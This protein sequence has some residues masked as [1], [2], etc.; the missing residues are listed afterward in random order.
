MN[1]SLSPR[2]YKRVQRWIRQNDF[3]V[4]ENEE[5]FERGTLS[6]WDLTSDITSVSRVQARTK[7]VCECD[8]IKVEERADVVKFESPF[9]PPQD[10]EIS[11]KPIS[12][13]NL[14]SISALPP[15]LPISSNQ[16]TK[17]IIAG[18]ESE[19]RKSDKSSEFSFK[20]I[21]TSAYQP[22]TT[23][24]YNLPS[25]TLNDNQPSRL[26]SSGGSNYMVPKMQSRIPDDPNPPS[27]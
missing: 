22:S 24:K 2:T 15:K 25:T 12:M 17:N 1:D 9:Q 19:L 26:S 7:Y 18:G 4:N 3:K 20:S 27:S 10:Y 6:T 23:L 8:D 11:A 14:T 13:I 5:Y 21:E 16:D